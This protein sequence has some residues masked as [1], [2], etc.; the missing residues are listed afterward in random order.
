MWN[1]H[2]LQKK[3]KEKEKAYASSSDHHFHHQMRTNE[4]L[5]PW[6]ESDWKDPSDW[7]MIIYK[8]ISSY[9]GGFF[10]LLLPSAFVFH[11]ALNRVKAVQ[12]E[13]KQDRNK[14]IYESVPQ[15]ENRPN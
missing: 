15:G 1:G 14:S 12:Q 11:C 6:P 13:A 3:E 7:M 4:R 5:S 9:D 8:I 2:E 10:P